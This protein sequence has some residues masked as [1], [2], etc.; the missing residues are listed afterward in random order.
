MLRSLTF[1]SIVFAMIALSPLPALAQDAPAED[2]TAVP[3]PI[4]R[5]GQVHAQVQL[6]TPLPGE[7]VASP[8]R[9]AGRARG[10]WYFEASFPVRVLG[11]DGRELGV[12]IA[13]AQA[14]WMTED[15]VPF[16]A[17]VTFDAPPDACLTLVLEKAN[18]SG[19][20]RNAGEVRVGL[21]CALEK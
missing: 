18:P 10:T 17:E 11:P 7:D 14:P 19:L 6:A 4:P 13:Q 20:P 8:L 5:A 1:P 2:V 16:D 9:V 21:R 12:G 3:P 15:W